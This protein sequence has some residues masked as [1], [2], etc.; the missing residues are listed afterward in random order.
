M[1]L[2]ILNVSKILGF[3]MRGMTPYFSRICEVI[4]VIVSE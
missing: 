1:N 3:Y 2:Y 4:A